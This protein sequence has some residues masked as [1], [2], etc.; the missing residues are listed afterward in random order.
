M[1]DQKN[2]SPTKAPTQSE[3]QEALEKQVAQLKREIAKINRALVRARR[4]GDGGG[5]RLVRNSFGSCHSR[6]AAVEVAGAVGF[7]D[8]PA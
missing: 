2:D 7:R 6:Y 8:G 3:A 5:R 4:R 1:A